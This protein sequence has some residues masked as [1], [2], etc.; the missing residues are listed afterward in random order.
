MKTHESVVTE[1]E[2][3]IINLLDDVEKANAMNPTRYLSIVKTKLEE[4]LMWCEYRRK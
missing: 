1:I 4:A 3:G 2:I